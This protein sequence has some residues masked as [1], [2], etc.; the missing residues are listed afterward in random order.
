MAGFQGLILPSEV[1]D[2]DYT[3]FEGATLHCVQ[4]NMGFIHTQKH[5]IY[6]L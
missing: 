4:Q 6:L 2:N 1:S 5:Q 3:R